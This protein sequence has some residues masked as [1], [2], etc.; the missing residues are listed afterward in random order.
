MRQL[1]ANPT[2]GGMLAS[3]NVSKDPLMQGGLDAEKQQLQTGQGL[4]NDQSGR[5]TQMQ[6]QGFQL[7]PED[8]TL[9]GQTSGN[10]AR[11]FG[12]QGN[13]AASNLAMRGMSNSGAA[14][15]TFSGL[16]GNQNEMLAQAQQQIMQQR[17]QN[18]Q[19]QIAQQQQFM[20][21]L[22]SQNNQMAGKFA[23]T[24]GQYQNQA[25][26]QNME[27]M[28]NQQGQANNEIK[29][30]RRPGSRWG[31]SRFYYGSWWGNTVAWH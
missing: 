12:Q 10:I 13:A 1:A 14:G 20:G 4:F 3:Y 24:S 19:N 31:W 28:G 29:N 23:D 8:Q 26:N 18:T 6:N 22:N 25:F 7:K 2:T 9:Y 30:V 21:N 16:Q 27:S 11:M 17:F 5:L 15:A